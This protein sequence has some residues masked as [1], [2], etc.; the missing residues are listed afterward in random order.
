M[1]VRSVSFNDSLPSAWEWKTTTDTV[2]EGWRG[3]ATCSSSL[4]VEKEGES[5][6]SSFRVTLA[7][8]AG[9]RASMGAMIQWDSRHSGFTL[10]TE[11]QK[12]KEKDK[13]G[14]KTSRWCPQRQSNVTTSTTP[15]WLVKKPALSCCSLHPLHKASFVLWLRRP[16]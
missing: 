10:Q 7:G 1:P 2:V 6:G 11:T 15:P 14:H 5:D 16:P 8:R 9:S 4:A 13:K 12:Y 3:L